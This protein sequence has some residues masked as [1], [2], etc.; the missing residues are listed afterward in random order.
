MCPLL[1]LRLTVPGDVPV[2]VRIK[3]RAGHSS[4]DNTARRSVVKIECP[5]NVLGQPPR[6]RPSV[7]PHRPVEKPVDKFSCETVNKQGPFKNERFSDL[8]HCGGASEE[9]L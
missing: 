8:H 5:A 3:S 6:V 7:F 4:R 1:P 2:D 9:D